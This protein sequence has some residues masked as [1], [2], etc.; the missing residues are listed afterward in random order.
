MTHTQPTKAKEIT[1]MWQVVDVGDKTLGREA[2]HI[3]QLL[4]GK[5]KPYFVRHLDCGDYVVVINAKN[6]VVTGKKMTQ[7]LY[8]SYSGYPGGLR[9]EPLRD[10]LDRRPDEVV[11]R[12]VKGM[13]PK[14]KLRDRMM[15]RLYVF[16]ENEHPYKEKLK[17]SG[18]AR[19]RPE[20]QNPD[21]KT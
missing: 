2:T 8:T 9:R 10:L 16:A 6:V 14:N 21:L 19:S 18:E 12:A 17:T 11:R 1:H 4:M 20:G 13:L 15:E 3:A 7:K 5:S